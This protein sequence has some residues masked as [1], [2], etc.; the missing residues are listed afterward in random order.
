MKHINLKKS[1]SLWMLFIACNLDVAIRR[2]RNFSKRSQDTNNIVPLFAEW[3]KITVSFVVVSFVSHRSLNQFVAR[4]VYERRLV[5][6]KCRKDLSYFTY[7]KPTNRIQLEGKI[8]YLLDIYNVDTFILL[9]TVKWCNQHCWN[10]NRLVS[11]VAIQ[12]D[13]SIY[14]TTKFDLDIPRTQWEK[15]HFIT[16]YCNFFFQTISRVEWNSNVYFLYQI[17]SW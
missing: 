9:W 5:S 2:Y 15:T 10:T 4:N 3:N 16:K 8:T 11:V 1:F 17:I 6:Y 13:Q 14:N 12:K 7:I